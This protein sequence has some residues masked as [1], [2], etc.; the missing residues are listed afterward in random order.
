MSQNAKDTDSHIG[1][2]LKLRDLQILASVAEPVTTE[3]VMA[4]A[5]AP[6]IAAGSRDSE[7]LFGTWT[8]EA[9]VPGHIKALAGAR[10]QLIYSR[11]MT[12]SVLLELD[13]AVARLSH[14]FRATLSYGG[15]F[16]IDEDAR[17]L[18]HDIEASSARFGTTM[19]LRR[20][21]FE[22]DGDVLVLEPVEDPG[23][24]LRWRRARS[25]RPAARKSMNDKR[26]PKGP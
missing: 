24:E 23:S 17:L 26:I 14:P 4:S 22:E 21:R 20:F 6:A 19:L 1:R 10:G 9:L 8:L 2:R 7:R 18:S 25:L 15:A 3:P 11:E 13:D 12:M 16:D 5:V